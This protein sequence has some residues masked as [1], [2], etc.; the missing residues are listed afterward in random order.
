MDTISTILYRGHKLLLREWKTWNHNVAR[1]WSFNI[2]PTENRTSTNLEDMKRK[3]DDYID[4]AIH[5]EQNK[6]LEDAAIVAFN[7]T[8]KNHIKE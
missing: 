6:K 8:F 7:E 1:G 2:S 4:N 5:H 3:V